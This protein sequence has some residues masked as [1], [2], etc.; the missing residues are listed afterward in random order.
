MRDAVHFVDVASRAR[1]RSTFCT[2]TVRYVDLAP[3][4]QARSTKCT[5]R[6]GPDTLPPSRSWPGAA[7]KR[8]ARPEGAPGAPETHDSAYAR[9]GATC[10]AP[11]A[12]ASCSAGSPG[13]WL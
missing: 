4:E 6:G 13:G 2:H 1:A 8:P 11:A 5:A 7:D 3:P 9:A 12:W 10:A